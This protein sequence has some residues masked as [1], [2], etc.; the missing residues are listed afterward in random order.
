MPKQKQNKT[1]SN[2]KYKLQK[3]IDRARKSSKR[4]NLSEE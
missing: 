4:K 2:N 3:A 1:K